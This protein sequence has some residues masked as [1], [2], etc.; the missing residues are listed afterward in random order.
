MSGYHIKYISFKQ[1][2]EINQVYFL[3]NN[4]TYQM[5]A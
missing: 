3:Q 5:K 4:C 1:M 2:R